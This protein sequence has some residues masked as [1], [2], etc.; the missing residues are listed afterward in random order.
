MTGIAQV[1]AVLVRLA[2]AVGEARDK[3]ARADHANRHA[4]VT[5][6]PRYQ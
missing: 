1:A 3:A 4:R 2:Q 5:T 6:A